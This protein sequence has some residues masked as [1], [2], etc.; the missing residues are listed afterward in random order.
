VLLL[1]TVFATS[2]ILV[3]RLTYPKVGVPLN[4]TITN[5][6]SDYPEL[7]G[8]DSKIRA[9]MQRWGLNGACVAVVRNDSLVYAKGYGYADV[10]KKEQMQPYHLMRVASVSKLITAAGIMSLVDQGQLRL[11]DHVFGED[12][13]LYGELYD[14]AYK[15]PNYSKITVEHLLRH[16]AGFG[17]DPMFSPSLVQSGLGIT[18]DPTGDD[19]IRYALKRRIV[20]RPGETSRYSNLGFYL[21]SRVIESVADTDY[22]SFIQA[23][24]M[25]PIGC[26]EMHIAGNLYTDRF[27]N[28][29]KYYS[30]DPSRD[31][32]GDNDITVLS[33]AG[34]WCCSI[35]E[36]AKFVAA[37]DGR[38]EVEDVISSY[39]VDDMTRYVDS[40][41]FSLGWNDTNPEVGWTRT[42]TF[43]G[44]SA[45]IKYFPD[46]ECWIFVTNTST[47]KGPHLA[48]YTGEL[49]RQC[50]EQ[51]SSRLPKK[52]MFYYE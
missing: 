17:G 39:S 2:G 46:G 6:N 27:P 24:I 41:I 31:A 30:H 40:S 38:P 21:L 20:Y 23:N 14:D 48:S 15:D 22:E 44:T 42:G 45:L 35:L 33:G 19:Y 11:D 26:S 12:G 32:Y 49:F 50:R 3:T 18:R 13:V 7:Y 51:Y 36:L 4:R 47:W 29:S 43:T 28:E 1:V 5:A 8:M 34:A 52:N 16:Q 9:Y 10:E 25:D 37:I